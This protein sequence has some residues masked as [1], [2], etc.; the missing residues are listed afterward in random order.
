VTSEQARQPGVEDLLR[1]VVADDHPLFLDG[2]RALIARAPGM[3]VVGTACTGEE[4]VT[5]VQQADPD[6]VVTDLRM[7]GMPVIEAIRRMR[8]ADAER[9]ILVLTMHDE[10][11]LVQ[12]ALQAGARGYALKESA[13]DAVLAAI[14]AI[15]QG[16]LVLGPGIQPTVPMAS[17]AADAIGQVFP[18]LTPRERDVVRLVAEGRTNLA[19]ARSLGLSEKTVRN[20]LSTIL[21]KVRI[22]D[23]AALIDR[24]RQGTGHGAT[25][26]PEA[27]SGRR[28]AGP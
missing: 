4:L 3:R 7:P 20:S 14:A 12:A 11:D 28:Q 18:G 16:M 24:T 21:A 17:A 6:V 15:R 27:R 26:C 5:A 8:A 1:V 19:I 10:N 25:Y 13:P 23:R 22:T 2:I 9:K